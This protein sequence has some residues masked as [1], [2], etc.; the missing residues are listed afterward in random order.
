LN[1]KAS[2]MIDYCAAVIGHIKLN[3]ISLFHKLHFIITFSLILNAERGTGGLI[4]MIKHFIIAES[5]N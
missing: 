4:N 5:F 2:A 1:T 3:Y